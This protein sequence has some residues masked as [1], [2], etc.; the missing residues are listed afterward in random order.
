MGPS[1]PVGVLRGPLPKAS[2]CPQNYPLSPAFP[3]LSSPG[4]PRSGL[5]LTPTQHLPH[6]YPSEGPRPLCSLALP[7]RRGTAQL[8]IACVLAPFLLS[9]P[10]TLSVPSASKFLETLQLPHRPP[11]LQMIPALQLKLAASCLLLL[12]VSACSWGPV[13][14]LPQGSQSLASR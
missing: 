2:P 6:T 12:I 9:W 11:H 14:S 3:Q 10:P 4:D 8:I 7:S 13:H 5:D 1:Y